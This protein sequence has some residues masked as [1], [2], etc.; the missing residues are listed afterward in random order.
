ML[1]TCVSLFALIAKSTDRFSSNHLSWYLC[2]M[3]WSMGVDGLWTTSLQDWIPMP[4]AFTSPGGHP[5]HHVNGQLA[6]GVGS[7]FWFSLNFLA[8][9]ICCSELLLVICIGDSIEDSWSVQRNE[10]P[11]QRFISW[12]ILLPVEVNATTIGPARKSCNKMHSMLL[13]LIWYDITK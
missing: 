8:D 12:G 1:I 4:L 6:W 5:I 3:S 9:V 7:D 13:N 11:L 2:W 10:V